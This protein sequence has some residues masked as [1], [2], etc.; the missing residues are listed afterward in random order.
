MREVD[1]DG[2]AAQSG[3][4]SRR[5]GLD[6]DEAAGTVLLVKLSCE[7]KVTFG[8]DGAQWAVRRRGCHEQ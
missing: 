5:A 2:A 4:R 7:D 6:I 3:E 1:S 8:R